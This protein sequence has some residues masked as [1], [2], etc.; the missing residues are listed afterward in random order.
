MEGKLPGGVSV[1]FSHAYARVIDAV[2]D[3]QLS[4]SPRHLS[5]IGVQIPL[6][7]LHLGVE[8]QYVGLRQTLR[9]EALAGVFLSNLTL[10][11]PAVRR[12]ELSLSVYN[13]FDAVYGDPG[14]EEH[15]QQSIPQNGRTMLASARVRF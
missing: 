13:A 6:A 5:K 2:Q 11:S 15:V 7:G 12:L 3:V 4:N 14:A 9:G 8:G 1:H 10:T